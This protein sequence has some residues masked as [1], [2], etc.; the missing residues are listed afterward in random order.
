MVI[1]IIQARSSSSRLPNKVMSLIL[2]KPMIIHE[3]ERVERAKL[4]DKIVLATS[5]DASDDALAKT[6]SSAGFEVYRG[7]LDDVLNRYVSCAHEYGAKPTDHIVRITGDCP[8]IDHEVVDDVIAYHI[9]SHDD[10]TNLG[11]PP[12]FP[13]GLDTEIMTFASL[14]QSQK[15]AT[16]P[17]EHEHLTQYIIKHPEVFSIGSM[18]N[19]EDLSTMRWTVDEPADLDFVTRIYEALYPLNNDFLMDDILHF[20]QKHPEMMKINMGITRNE[21]LIKSLREDEEYLNTK[22]EK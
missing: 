21:G 16:L 3:L 1:A 11:E 5:T 19:D 20:L 12:T 13:D 9:D 18:Q 22:G 14:I 7:S 6:V 17:S 10:Y 8:L 4:I 2:G 15:K